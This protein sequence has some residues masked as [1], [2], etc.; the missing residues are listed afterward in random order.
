MSPISVSSSTGRTRQR[1]GLKITLIVVLIIAL[2]QGL[3]TFLSVLSFEKIYLKALL[4][5]YEVLGKDLQRQ[6]QQALRFGKPLDLFLGMDRLV[7]PLFKQA[8]ELSDVFVLSHEGQVLFTFNRVRFVI[9]R[10]TVDEKEYP[11]G[12]VLLSEQDTKRPFPLQ[13]LDE[14]QEEESLIRI[15]DGKY[16]VIFPIK[17]MQGDLKGYL[18]LAFNSSMLDRK[19]GDLI[20]RSISKL[21]LA[22][23]LTAVSVALLIHFAFVGPGRRQVAQASDSLE[24]PGGLPLDSTSGRSPAEVL[25]VQLSIADYISWT[26]DVK[27]E[28]SQ[29]LEVL[30]TE[31]QGQKFPLHIILLMKKILQ[32]GSHEDL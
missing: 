13:Y 4:S 22:I 12:K 5:K 6:I 19:K 28:V 17:P 11:R 14:L 25:E 1:F 30:K 27:K 18:G 3:G 24:P 23:L 31:V 9:A 8:E 10:G 20:R 29:D 26:R 32:G 15:H 7:E 16:Y 21:L 2:S